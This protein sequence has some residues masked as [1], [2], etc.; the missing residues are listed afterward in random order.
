MEDPQG[1]YE[2]QLILQLNL[3]DMVSYETCRY[4]VHKP[5]KGYSKEWLVMK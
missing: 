4:K 3:L 1:R 2:M 5:Q